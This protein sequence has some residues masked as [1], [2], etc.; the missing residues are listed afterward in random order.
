MSRWQF[1]L[2]QSLL[3]CDVGLYL[4]VVGS[5]EFHLG[6]AYLVAFHFVCFWYRMDLTGPSC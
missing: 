6:Q 4:Q 1:P 5:H 3:L 2:P